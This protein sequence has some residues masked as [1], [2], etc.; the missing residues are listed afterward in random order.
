MST[1]SPQSPR[2]PNTKR[3]QRRTVGKREGLGVEFSISGKGDCCCSLAAGPRHK[4]R[5]FSVEFFIR[6]TDQ[7]AEEP[8]LF[9]QRQQ[10]F[11][12]A[13]RFLWRRSARGRFA[14]SEVER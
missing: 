10:S 9:A 12:R 1:M 6:D 3:R 14:R 13:L 4:T 2:L 8:L 5:S 11:R 7:F